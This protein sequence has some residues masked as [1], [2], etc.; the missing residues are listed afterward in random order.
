MSVKWFRVWYRPYGKKAFWKYGWFFA[1][2]SLI[3][4]N[5]TI[6]QTCRVKDKNRWTYQVQEIAPGDFDYPKGNDSSTDLSGD[7]R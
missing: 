3:H 1:S 4:A 7:S 2:D 5:E 6:D